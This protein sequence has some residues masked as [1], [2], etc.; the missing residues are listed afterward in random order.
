MNN[1]KE[2]PVCHR[3]EDLVSY[4]YGE[5][6]ASDARDFAEHMDKCDSCRG[7][8]ESFSHVHESIELWRN[9]ALGSISLRTPSPMTDE[10][11]RTYQFEQH[12]RERSARAA[13]REFFVRSPLWLRGATAFATLLLCVLALLM[14]SRIWQ[15]SPQVATN[16]PEKIFT[17]ADFDQA[18][19]RA[20]EARMNA[21]K[22]AQ[23]PTSE[24]ATNG[25]TVRS[26]LQKTARLQTARRPRTHLTPQEREQLAADLRLIPGRED[27]LPFVFSDVPEQ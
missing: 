17:R 13:L 12:E 4:L 2:R 23:V 5:A 8:F 19:N 14:V 20:V 6:S 24:N 27:D 21:L 3:A 1:M 11:A 16:N 25:S 18:V 26:P 9:E 7:E 22:N 15:H 10:V